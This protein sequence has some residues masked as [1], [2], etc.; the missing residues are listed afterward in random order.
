MKEKIPQQEPTQEK[1]K[2][3]ISKQAY[4]GLESLIGQLKAAGI[5][6]PPLR[7]KAEYLNP[8]ST[9]AIEARA[10]ETIEKYGLMVPRTKNLALGMARYLM[11]AEGLSGEHEGLN[12]RRADAIRQLQATYL[13]GKI[14][15]FEEGASRQY[16]PVCV[17]DVVCVAATAKQDYAMRHGKTVERFREFK[18]AVLTYDA[19]GNLVIKATPPE[20]LFDLDQIEI[21]RDRP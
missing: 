4:A 10:L 2:L 18:I 16:M 6:E 13:R 3:I 9:D 12:L 11:G 1:R 5:P 14:M 7:Q 19:E 17:L 15:I 20:Q 8:R 21:Q